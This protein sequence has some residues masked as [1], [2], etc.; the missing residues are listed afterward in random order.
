MYGCAGKG[1]S[2]YADYLAMWYSKFLE[3]EEEPHIKSPENKWYD[4][5]MGQSI[6]IADDLE[7]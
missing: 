3:L 6:V 7:A 4:G 5:Y 2:A 1:K